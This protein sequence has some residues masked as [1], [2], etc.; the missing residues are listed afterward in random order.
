M[1]IIM[2]ISELF[3]NF[4]NDPAFL[5]PYVWLGMIAGAIVSIAILMYLD[6]KG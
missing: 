4:D 5:Y 2:A 3:E 1:G 6:W